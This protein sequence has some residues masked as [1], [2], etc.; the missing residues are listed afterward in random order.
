M[1]ENMLFI[2]NDPPYGSEKL[3]NALR[4]A[5]SVAKKQ[6][7]ETIHIFLFGDSVVAAKKSQKVAQGYYNLETMLKGLASR[8][9]IISACGTCMDARG[10][11]DEEL[12]N[13]IIRGSMDQ[14]GDWT[15][16]AGKIL[17]F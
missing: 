2:L 1:M 7:S 3:Y 5:L 4:L 8:G 14:L 12:L 16:W 11:G 10:M 15:L 6:E 17:V 9:V 13:G